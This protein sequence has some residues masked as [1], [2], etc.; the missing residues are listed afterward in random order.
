MNLD[1][2]ETFLAV[3]R[4]ESFTKAAPQVHR[5]QSAVSRQIQ[6]LERSLGVPLFE[7]LGKQVLLT[8]AGRMLLNDAPLLLQQTETLR[9]RL[10]DIG[11]GVSGELRIGA[12]VTAANTFIPDV[13]AQFRLRYP[14]VNLNL[15]PGQS[16]LLARRLRRNELDVAVLGSQVEEADLTACLHIPDQIV[17]VASPDHPLTKKRTIKPAQLDGVDFILRESGSDSRTLVDHW[18]NEQ[19]VSINMLMDLW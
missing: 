9:G 10:R 4:T 14:A 6:E 16:K 3:A 17:M 18:I 15:L 13:L 5:T 7:R 11:Q 1:Q 12:T 8:N 19:Q 2:L